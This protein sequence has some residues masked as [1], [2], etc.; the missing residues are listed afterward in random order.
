MYMLFS[1]KAH[2][3]VDFDFKTKQVTDFI[4]LWNQGKSLAE[5]ATAIRRNE[6]E[7]ALL[8][9]DLH[10][11]EKINERPNGIFGSPLEM[12]GETVGH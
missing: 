3:F 12:E 9:M 11:L 1:Q 6:V 7:C 10:I 2:E 8:A 4:E 5:I